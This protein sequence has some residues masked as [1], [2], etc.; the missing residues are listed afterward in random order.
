MTKEEEIIEWVLQFGDMP[1]PTDSQ[2]S[3]TEVAHLIIKYNKDKLAGKLNVTNKKTCSNCRCKND[4]PKC[5]QSNGV[6]C[7]DWLKIH[8]KRK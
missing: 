4:Y 2:F 8:K 5:Y 3:A 6:A 7:E 1:S